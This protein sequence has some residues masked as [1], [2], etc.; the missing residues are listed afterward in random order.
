MSDPKPDPIEA[1]VQ[2]FFITDAARTAAAA[3]IR[4]LVTAATEQERQ[5]AERAEAKFALDHEGEE[6]VSFREAIRSELI[7]GTMKQNEELKG[8]LSKAEAERDEALRAMTT[9]R[10]SITHGGVKA[11]YERVKGERDAALRERDEARGESLI[12]RIAMRKELDAAQAEAGKLREGLLESRMALKAIRRRLHFVGMI[13][14]PRREDGTPDW[15]SA[16]EVLE[17]TAAKIE[18]AIN[19]R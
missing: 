19:G 11:S 9:L 14:E 3:K 6:H 8:K 7:V 15:R 1:L 17:T 18:E 13:Q 5:R 16:I 10:D 12:L 4:A 2:E